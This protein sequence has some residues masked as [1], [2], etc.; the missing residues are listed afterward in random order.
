[1]N[2][3]WTFIVGM[4]T[5]L[6][7]MGLDQ[8]HSMLGMMLAGQL[9]YDAKKDELK[10]YLDSKIYEADLEMQSNMYKLKKF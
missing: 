10:V 4:L 9:Q 7:P 3:Y 8:I 2:V 1:M 6:G 5:N